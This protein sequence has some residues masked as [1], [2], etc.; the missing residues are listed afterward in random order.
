MPILGGPRPGLEPGYVAPQATRFTA[1]LTSATSAGVRFQLLL[2]FL[3][4]YS[5]LFDWP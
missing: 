3:G 5:L 1:Y 2:N 4:F